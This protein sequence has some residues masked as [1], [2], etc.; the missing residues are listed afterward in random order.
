MSGNL[1]H[2]LPTLVVGL[3]LFGVVAMGVT[4]LTLHPPR[5]LGLAKAECQISGQVTSQNRPVTRGTICFSC[6]MLS[7]AADM[8]SFPDVTVRIVDGSYVVSGE[9]GL[10]P[11]RYEVTIRAQELGPQD[12]EPVNPVG[13][14]IRYPSHNLILVAD[15]S[16]SFVDFEL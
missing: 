4:S 9:D 8:D 5:V 16:P 12:A 2:R 6:V 14:R 7:D 1:W 10:V 13:H 3:L 11:G 15:G